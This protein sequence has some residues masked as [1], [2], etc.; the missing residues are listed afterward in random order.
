MG[1]CDG[2][3]GEITPHTRKG[4]NNERGARPGAQNAKGDPERMQAREEKRMGEREENERLH[5]WVNGGREDGS[6]RPPTQ[7]PVPPGG[8]QFTQK[9]RPLD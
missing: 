1:C 9:K 4:A 5:E 3:E 6:A 7:E 8:R 2:G